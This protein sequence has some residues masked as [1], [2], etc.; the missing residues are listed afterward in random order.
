MVL[1]LLFLCASFLPL[2]QDAPR[3]AEVAADGASLHAFYD[4]KSAKVMDLP[5]GMPVQIVAEFTPWSKVRIPGGFDVWVHQDYVQ[6]EGAEGRISR[7]KVRIRPQPSTDASSTPIGH[8]AQGDLV[9][10]LG[11]EGDWVHVRAPESISAWVLS[12]SL[13]HPQRST[14]DW[15]QRWQQTMQARQ[16]VLVPVTKEQEEAVEEVPVAVEAET[17]VAANAVAEAS[18]DG[19]AAKSAKESWHRWHAA[20][21][22]KDPT[23]AQAMA[24]QQLEAYAKAVTE[25]NAAWN[26][27]HLDNLE[28]VFGNVIWHT[29]REQT[30]NAARA[31]LTRIDGLRRFYLSS[32]AADMR[33]A[34][35]AK[36]E[37]LAQRLQQRIEAEKQ[38][39]P[40][41]EEGTHVEIGWVEYRPSVNA[42]IPFR[43]VRGGREIPMHSYD[44]HQNL[45][46]L[47]N[48]EIVVRGVW[49]QE[50]S[51]RAGRVLAITEL[52]VLP[53]R[54][55]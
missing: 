6:W 40:T 31:S 19:P 46:A 29:S 5:A 13:S 18:A 50:A 32:L 3:Y 41:A 38:P 25:D 20:E 39:T 14:Q 2:Q 42:N 45:K 21:V 26:R 55:P 23:Q 30:L 33:R 22:A 17:A 1:P 48:R 47:V 11:A 16:A 49:R 43:L 28:M 34:L 37:A 51:L 7:A 15:Q 44:G 12:K 9:L 4:R 27:T 53:P 36:K 52:R 10:R 8:F 35:A 54:T 24:A